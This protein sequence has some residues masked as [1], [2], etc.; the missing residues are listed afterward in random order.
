MAANRQWRMLFFFLGVLVIASILVARLT[1]LMLFVEDDRESSIIRTRGFFEVKPAKR[2]NIYDRN[3]TALAVTYPV[4]EVGIDP[5]FFDWQRSAEW[6]QLAQLLK[7]DP[8]ELWDDLTQRYRKHPKTRW[9]KISDNT[10]ESIYQKILELDIKGV[11]GNRK[12]LRKYPQNRLGCHVIGFINKENK[13]CC[14]VEKYLDFFLKG[15]DGWILSEK[16]G[17]RQ[18]LLQYRLHDVPESPG[19][20][21]QLTIDVQIQKLVQDALEKLVEDYH[22]DF[23]TIIISEAKTGKIL[24]LGC[25]PDYDPNYFNQTPLDHLRNRAITDCYEPGS[26]FK[27]VAASAGLED[28]IVQPDTVFD[29]SLANFEW[30][31]KTYQ[32]PKDY[33][34]F[35]EMTLTDVLRKSS[36]RGSAQIAI[37]LGDE[38]FYSY[39]KAFGF[40][41]KTGYGF[42]GEVAGIL[43]PPNLWDGLTI[44]RMPMGH[45]IAVTPLQVHMAMSV[46]AS[47]GYLLTPLLVENIHAPDS[48]IDVGTALHQTAYRRKVLRKS[49]VLQ[50]RQML[51]NPADIIDQQIPICCKTGTAQKIVDG[52]YV[53]NRHVASTSGFFPA[54]KPKFVIT[55]VIDSP[56][57][58]NGGITWGGT[59]A[60]P[61]FKDLARSLSKLPNY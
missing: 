5:L 3:G 45:A 26:V 46:L 9:L 16:D 31:E 53:H 27:I 23:A 7:Q 44:T 57:S 54:M 21:V 30:Q 19:Y 11:Y 52:K 22:P 42:D 28:G 37:R 15:Q 35:G 59:Y 10:S 4:V 47:D 36:N 55:V 6:D 25:T 17:C 12:F 41:E 49:T 61:V 14:G 8:Q 48:T 20:D 32:L 2:G 29:C 18:E 51:A 34:N 1:Q 39:V 56:E 43:R 24:A 60:K 50:M 33:A 38:K 13:A 58:K 40:G